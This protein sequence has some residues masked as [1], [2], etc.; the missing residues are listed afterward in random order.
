MRNYTYIDGT[1]FSVANLFRSLRFDIDRLD[2]SWVADQKPVF[3]RGFRIV[4]NRGGN[5]DFISRKL[6]QLSRFFH[7]MYLEIEFVNMPVQLICMAYS[8]Q[9]S[10]PPE[11]DFSNP[12]GKPLPRKR[13]QMAGTP[14][15][16]R[17]RELGAAYCLEYIGKPNASFCTKEQTAKHVANLLKEEN[18]RAKGGDYVDY[19]TVV[20]D[21]FNDGWWPK[22]NPSA[23]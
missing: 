19:Q 18:F 21:A 22:H 15:I 16:P 8:Y 10:L 14:W 1:R 11:F 5:R 17:A 2:M 6:G 7:W 9:A 12:N 3:S 13:T 23:K 4:D 20:R